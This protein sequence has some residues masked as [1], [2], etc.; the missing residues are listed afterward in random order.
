VRTS[1]ACLD[2]VK[3]LRETY[4]MTDVTPLSYVSSVSPDL[5]VY[6]DPPEF[7]ERDERSAFEPPAFYGC[8][9]SVQEQPEDGQG[10]TPWFRSGGGRETRVYISFGTVIWRYYAA[11][12]ARALDTIAASFAGSKEL[13]AI[14]SLGGTGVAGTIVARWIRPSVSVESYVDQ[15]EVLR[16][17]GIFVTHHG[18][19]STHK[20]IFHQVPMISYPFLWISR[21]WPRGAGSSGWPSRSPSPCAGNSGRIRCGPRWRGLP[22]TGKGCTRRFAEPVN[23]SS[24]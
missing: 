8:L 9:P 3:I 5:N 7:L 17:A 15:W 24:P 23:G 10:R 22:R 20:A 11:E 1:R 19:N 21:G 16:E 2:A 18:T 12:A 14:I 4:G 6:C 13:E